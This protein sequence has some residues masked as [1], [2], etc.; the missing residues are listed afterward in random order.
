MM[1]RCLGCMQEFDSKLGICPY[2]GYEIGTE[3]EES[4]HMIPGTLL[5]DRYI[6]GKVLGYGGFGVTY[7]GWDGKLEQKVA[8]KEYLPGEFSTRMPGQSQVT[9]FNGDKSEQFCDGMKKFIDEAKRLAKFK[10]EYGI[11]KI[12]DSFEEN[13]TAYIIMEFLEGETLTSYLAREKTIPED[14]AIKMIT[15]I[16]KSLKV[17]HEAGLLHRDI[18]PDNIFL[19]SKGDVKLID[20][21]ASRHATTSHS[22]SLTV[23]IKQGYSPEEQY[24]SRGDQGPYTDVYSLAATLYKMLT[25]ET[26]PDAMERHSKY[27]SKNKDILVEPHKLNK[28]IS[29]NVEN[30]ILNAMNIK[31]EDRTQDIETFYEELTSTTY[32][33]RKKGHIKRINLYYWPL[34]LKILVPSILSVVIVLSTLLMTGVINFSLFSREVEIPE[35]FVSVPNVEGLNINEAIKELEEH[36]L[37]PLTY[38]TV[39]SEYVSAGKVVLQNP[40]ENSQAKKNSKILLTVSRGGTVQS[41]KEGFAIIPY[42]EFEKQNIAEQKLEQA[43]LGKPKIETQYDDNV[44]EGCVISQSIPFG[45]EVEAETVITLVV[46]K[47]PKSFKMINV[48]GLNIKEGEKLL[49]DNGLVVSIEYKNDKS[50]PKGQILSQSVNANEAVKPGTNIVVVIAGGKDTITVPNVLG[51]DKASADKML[52]D[53]HLVVSYYNNYSETVPEGCVVSQDPKPNSQQIAG[54]QISI[55]ISSGKRPISVNLNGNGGSVSTNTINVHYDEAYSNLP[56]PSRKGYTFTGWYTSASGGSQVNASTKVKTHENH[57]LYAHWSPVKVTVKFNASGGTVDT[58]SKSVEFDGKYGKLPIPTNTGYAF[59]GWYTSASGGEK[60]TENTTVNTEKTHELYA[61][62]SSVSFNI[63]FDANGGSVST[64]S[65]K[66]TY[67]QKYGELPTPAKKGNSFMGWFDSRTGGN[68]ITGDTVVKDAGI[69]VLYAH[70]QS[71]NYNLY[72]N[73]NGGSVSTR[74]KSITFGDK[75]GSLPTPDRSHYTFEGWYTA[76]NGGSRVSEYT[77]LDRE[78]DVT[79]YAHWTQKAASGWVRASQMPSGAKPV[80][81]KYTYT[82]RTYKTSSSSSMN[83]WT[84]YD[85]KRTSWGATQGP[86][87]SDPNNGSRKVW[88]EQYVASQTTHYKYYHRYSGNGKWGSDSTARSWARHEIDLTYPLNF[89][90]NGSYGIKWYYSYTCPHCG[91]K[92]MWIPDGTYV[93]DNYATRWY[94]QEPVYTYYFYRDE[95]KESYSRPSGNDIRNVEEWIRYIPA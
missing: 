62:W 92:N 78:N 52:K 20:F 55:C 32:V 65:K 44:P 66:V 75:Y 94:Y 84:K 23:I 16:I 74:Q 71:N 91:A 31:I 14:E 5:H 13:D 12:F 3:A 72:F 60:I 36:A 41:S 26:P 64:T 59:S 1:H 21:G 30:A 82:Q 73:A 48:V 70:W 49:V 89:R 88:S 37:L 43:G 68:R 79:V 18:A 33:K 57:S 29:V 38:G 27:E 67:N 76:P 86:V 45:E 85:T 58:A 7:I 47:G 35:G 83:G 90:A 61:Q 39:E 51:K 40:T 46:S 93:V 9:V 4:V 11:V 25:G 69:K 54:A 28:N 15:P 77:T 6:V 50:V 17:V 53:S 24:R 56:S 22:R 19:T 10:N 34:W 63:E 2:C 81:T 87:Y 80:D 95:N 8:I 42:V